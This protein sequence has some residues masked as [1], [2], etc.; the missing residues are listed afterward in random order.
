MEGRKRGS[1]GIVRPINK[2]DSLGKPVSS[3]VL[4]WEVHPQV[5]PELFGTPFFCQ[6]RLYGIF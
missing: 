4:D 1:D 5:L 3:S 2:T 6:A